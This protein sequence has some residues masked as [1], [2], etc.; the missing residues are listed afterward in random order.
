MNRYWSE[1]RIVVNV[2]TG[3]KYRFWKGVKP[4]GKRRVFR[5]I[6]YFDKKWEF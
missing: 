1:V 4:C 2:G 5:K 3:L 6:K